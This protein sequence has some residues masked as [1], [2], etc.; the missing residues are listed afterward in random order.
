VCLNSA[1]GY[2]A[3]KDMLAGRQREI[4]AR[5]RCSSLI[6][7]SEEFCQEYRRTWEALFVSDWWILGVLAGPQKEH[8]GRL[9]Q[10]RKAL[11]L[12]R[13]Q[14]FKKDI[15]QMRR[16]WHDIQ[17]HQRAAVVFLVY[18]VAAALAAAR[19]SPGLLLLFATPLIAGALVGW[20]RSTERILGGLLAG[21]LTGA[22]VSLVVDVREVV[23]WIQHGR[24]RGIRGDEMLEW[25]V[26]LVVA[27][28]LLGMAGA[29]LA[30][31]LRRSRGG[32]WSEEDVHAGHR[33][34]VTLIAGLP[35]VALA[36]LLLHG[37]MTQDEV[38]PNY[39]Y[40]ADQRALWGVPNFWNV[41][42]NLPFLL[43]A[44]WGLR[45]V[46]TRAAFVEEWE[47]AACRILL[48]AVALVAVGSSY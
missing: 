15:A 8:F 19:D 24:V 36:F 6:Q 3:P 30:I 45:A 14:H 28:G 11:S 23:G 47:V 18:W 10:K 26:F 22:L 21:V 29:G 33:L 20:W 42:S 35:A 27:G 40:F 39:H 9:F 17:T 32:R 37:P 13:W 7:L 1:V 16:L 5:T 41:V 43:A 34:R 46:H 4:H 44:L 2:I 12:W 38:L 31:L 48:I 25:L